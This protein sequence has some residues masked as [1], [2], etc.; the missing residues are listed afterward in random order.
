MN[1]ELRGSV[2][3]GLLSKREDD[4][5]F[6]P[7]GHNKAELKAARYK[8][9]FRA[10]YSEFMGTFIFFTM[11]FGPIAKCVKAGIDPVSTGIICTF[12]AGLTLIAV[13]MTF[14]SLSGAQLNPAITIALWATRKISNRKCIAFI[15]A[16][17]LAS[18]AVMLCIYG[19][20]PDVN[21]DLLKAISVQTTSDVSLGNIFFT[22]FL[23]TFILTYVAFSMAFEE[24]E[25]LKSSTMS[26]AAMEETDGL[27]MYSSTPQSKVGFAPFAIG[28]VLVGLVFYGGGSGICMN[29]ARLFGPALF[30]GV[31]D[32]WYMFF[33]GEILGA[34]AAGFLVDFGP[35]SAQRELNIKETVSAVPSN[36][37]ESLK[38]MSLSMQNGVNSGVNALRNAV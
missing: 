23:S 3:D 10:I 20:F 35:Q 32:K 30:S 29:P 31:W 1:N 7:S 5:E 33:L 21:H 11:I 12:A 16:Q 22:E 18:V 28:F 6:T 36:V 15:I 9:F 24:A 26:L 37:R 34:T 13:I 17:L 25:S 4:D 38:R 27:L 8:A 2:N 14:S 19:S